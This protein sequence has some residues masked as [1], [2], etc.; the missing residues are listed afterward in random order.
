MPKLIEALK[1]AWNA[2]APADTAP[3][4][5]VPKAK[6]IDPLTQ[7]VSVL[8]YVN[9]KPQNKPETVTHNWAYKTLPWVFACVRAIA[10]AGASVPLV[11]RDRETDEALDATTPRAGELVRVLNYVNERS[12]GAALVRHALSSLSLHGNALW[13]LDRGERETGPVLAIRP[14][15]PECCS[16]V[17]DQKTGDLV[18]YAYQTSEAIR[19]VIYPAMDVFHCATYNPEQ[20][21]WGLSDLE[22]LATTLS[23]DREAQLTN[24]HFMKN[25]ASPGYLLTGQMAIT[26]EQGKKIRDQWQ[27]NQ[28]GSEN[29]GRVI[30]LGGQEWKLE[31]LGMSLRDAQFSELRNMSRAETLAVMGVPPVILGLETA[32]YAT[33]KEQT[34]NFWTTT[35]Q[36]RLSHLASAINESAEKFGYD[37][38]AIY[39]DF[40]LSEVAALQP[41][42]LVLAQTGQVLLSS[43]QWTQDEVRERLY[44]MEPMK[45]ED[46]PEAPAEEEGPPAP[47]FTLL[48]EEAEAEAQ[49]ASLPR[50]LVPGRKASEARKAEARRGIWVKGQDTQAGGRVRIGREIVQV[51]RELTDEVLANIGGERKSHRKATVP[52]VETLLFDLDDA[53]Q[54]ILRRLGEIEWNEYLAYAESVVDLFNLGIDFDAT[55]ASAQEW[56]AARELQIVTIPETYHEELRSQIL[57]GYDEGETMAQIADRVEAFYGEAYGRYDRYGA[58]RIAI[59]ETNS[60]YNA[61]TVEAERQAGVE[62]HEWLHSYASAQPRPEHMATDGV[63]VALGEVFEPAGLAYPGD[64]DGEPEQTINCKCSLAPVVD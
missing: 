30:V 11:V 55:S 62:K 27:L 60:A 38:D 16:A 37:A 43:K 23:T 1:R 50:L 5:P 3:E 13:W 34:T 39:V 61:A 28:A 6:G 25:G 49:A 54:L 52:E 12:D 31:Q 9:G 59:T 10:T 24:L 64:P 48:R 7:S 53:G 35:V 47:P 22:A 15:R 46:Q 36:P 2:L 19:P 17:F 56:F 18:A 32:N 44:D 29:A 42:Y 26:P 51:Y 40:D 57:L 63:V 21:L 45:E 4:V 58:E 41:D 20:D 14:L 8:Q 33:A